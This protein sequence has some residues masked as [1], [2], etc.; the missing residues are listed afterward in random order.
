MAKVYL[1]LTSSAKTDFDEKK[2]KILETHN[3]PYEN[4]NNTIFLISQEC[5]N[6]GVDI[7][8]REY[9][10]PYSK[11]CMQL[12]D[13]ADGSIGMG[14][15]S[16]EDEILE[17]LY[18]VFGNSS[19]FEFSLACGDDYE[20]KSASIVLN[21]DV[22]E[23][24]TEIEEDEEDDEDEDV[25]TCNRCGN[26]Y[27][28]DSECDCASID[29]K[30]IENSL[31]KDEIDKIRKVCKEMEE[32]DIEYSQWANYFLS[33]GYNAK[34]VFNLEI[35]LE[36]FTF[37]ITNKENNLPLEINFIEGKFAGWVKS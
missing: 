9:D 21:A 20:N 35:T 16:L 4:S 32:E 12:A 3:I 1:T 28:L 34:K 29:S 18:N 37:E 22:Y 13:S 15:E 10:E 7:K 11:F 6:S 31:H 33:K 2:I 26:W 19:H 27:S 14:E 30:I 17:V 23:F 24:E 5:Y 25:V 36:Q 8:S